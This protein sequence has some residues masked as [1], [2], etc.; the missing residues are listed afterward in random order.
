MSELPSSDDAIVA[1]GVTKRY[2]RTAVLNGID[3]RVACG[4][5]AVLTG[6]S[7][8]GKSTLLNLLGALE[9]ADAGAITV[10][11]HGLGRHARRLSHF[12][13]CEV[14]MI[15]QLH[16]LIPRLT[17]REN[18][19]SV[20]FGTSRS[21][22]ERIARAT[23]LLELLDLGDRAGEQPPTL[24]GGERQR[25]AVAR[26]LAN[27]PPVVLADEPT[28]SL[29]D[30]SGALVLDLFGELIA[31]GTTILAVSHDARLNERADRLVRIVEGR[32]E[33]GS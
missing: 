11:G 20:M 18:I 10:G 33:P 31:G 24:S 28:G 6:P 8:S 7:G 30:V 14:G 1:E 22:K 13:R 3:L 19:E 15:F 4:E 21:R 29:D 25:V 26:A 27:D 5:F 23:E 17:A 16:N 12:R 2:G 9:T 32:V